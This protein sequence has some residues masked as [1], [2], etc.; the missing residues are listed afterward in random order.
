MVGNM[1]SVIL[2][3]YFLHEKW[4]KEQLKEQFFYV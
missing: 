2:A 1:H 4:K 3:A